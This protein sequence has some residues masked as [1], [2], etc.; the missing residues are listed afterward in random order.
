M[1]LPSTA[2]HP[3][4]PTS[5]QEVREEIKIENTWKGEE[6][7]GRNKEK[8]RERIRENERRLERDKRERKENKERESGTS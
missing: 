7:R 1:A 5:H 8:G 3:I 6:I 4:P 2:T